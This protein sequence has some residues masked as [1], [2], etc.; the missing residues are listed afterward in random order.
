MAGINLIESLV[1]KNTGLSDESISDAWKIVLSVA[2]NPE[3]DEGE[4]SDS[5]PISSKDPIL[6]EI[7]NPRINAIQVLIYLI[8]Y[9]KKRKRDVPVEALEVL[10]R[11]LRLTGWDGAEHRAVLAC[12]VKLLRYYLPDWFEQNE[13]FLFGNK[14]PESLAQLSLDIHLK[15]EYPDEYILE[16]YAKGVL[17]AVKRD[18]PHSMDCLL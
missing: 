18:I 9:A 6:D 11:A 5:A 13:L 7:N 12:H 16:R 17:N 3:S 8:E 1:K 10:T 15:W 14:A 2:A 4:S